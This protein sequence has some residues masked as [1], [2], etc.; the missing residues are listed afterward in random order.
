MNLY[1]LA[2]AVMD[3]QLTKAQAEQLALALIR[4]SWG[5][6]VEQAFKPRAVRS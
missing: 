6:S 2:R 1:Q 4:L 5:T 3:G